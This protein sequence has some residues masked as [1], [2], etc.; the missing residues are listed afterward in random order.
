MFSFDGIWIVLVIFI[1]QARD[2]YPSLNGFTKNEYIAILEFHMCL[3]IKI[4]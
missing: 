3:H 2:L 4:S 1:L